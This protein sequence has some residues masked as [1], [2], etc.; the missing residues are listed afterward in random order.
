MLHFIFMNGQGRQWHVGQPLPSRPVPDSGG[1][2]KEI[3]AD[4]DELLH[5]RQMFDNIP[6]VK[7]AVIARWPAPWAEF[8][9]CN[10]R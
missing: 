8:I 4:G 2:V 6:I 10:L 9:Y 3:Q 7:D 5:I 1:D